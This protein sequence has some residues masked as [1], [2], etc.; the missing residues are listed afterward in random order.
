MKNI[1]K[2]YTVLSV[3]LLGFSQTIQPKISWGQWFRSWGSSKLDLPHNPDNT[4]KRG[5]NWAMSLAGFG[6]LASAENEARRLAEAAMTDGESQ[7]KDLVYDLE[8]LTMSERQQVLNVW[9]H[10]LTNEKGLTLRNINEQIIQNKVYDML[11]AIEKALPSE[12]HIVLVK[13]ED[14]T[15]EFLI[16][17]TSQYSSIKSKRSSEYGSITVYKKDRDISEQLT[18]G[19]H[20]LGK[21][22][23]SDPA[24]QEQ[25]K[26]HGRGL[27]QQGL[28]HPG[29]SD[30]LRKNNGINTALARFGSGGYA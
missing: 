27:I 24:T 3:L 16:V 20:G 12:E 29:I 13:R 30:T 25:L 17:T 22:A 5:T 21:E 7:A 26:T 9:L 23:L 11:T 1:I 15:M 19:L 8:S 10:T 28:N 6:P 14:G 2:K 18:S 4:V